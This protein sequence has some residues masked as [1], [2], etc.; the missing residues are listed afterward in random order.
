MGVKDGTSATLGGRNDLRRRVRRIAERGRSIFRRSCEKY[1]AAG[2][3]NKNDVLYQIAFPS[4]PTA[5]RRSASDLPSD[6]GASI[7]RPGRKCASLNF[8]GMNHLFPGA[9]S[10]V[11][12]FHVTCRSRS[13]TVCQRDPDFA[14]RRSN[15]SAVDLRGSVAVFEFQFSQLPLIFLVRGD[16]VAVFLLDQQGWNS[17]VYF[18]WKFVIVLFRLKVRLGLIMDLMYVLYGVD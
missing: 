8:H 4:S 2:W 3:A 18:W 11:P 16:I 5:D 1:R 9:S 10:Q 12:Q 14:I 15:Y 6:A 7:L 17:L 13:E